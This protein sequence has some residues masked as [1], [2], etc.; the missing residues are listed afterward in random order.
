MDYPLMGEAN[1]FSTGPNGTINV[2][3]SIYLIPFR[4]TI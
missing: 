4:A 2:K 3:L 1:V